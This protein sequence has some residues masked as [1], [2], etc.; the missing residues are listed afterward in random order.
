MSKFVTVVKTSEL[1]MGQARQVELEDGTQICLAN[2]DGAFY[3]IGGACTHRGGPLGEGSL[4]GT[5]VT[6]PWHAGKFDV[7]SGEAKG[8]PVND[9]EPTFEVRL[10]GDDVQVAL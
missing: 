7:T 5:I 3:A 6:C 8:P 4:D 2:V 9:P 10:A 1:P